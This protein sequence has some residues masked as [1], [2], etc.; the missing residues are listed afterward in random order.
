MDE[1]ATWYGSRPRPRPHCVRQRPSSPHRERGTAAPS[2]RPMSIVATVANLSTAE[3]LFIKYP[4]LKG[5]S[6]SLSTSQNTVVM[7]SQQLFIVNMIIYRTKNNKNVLWQVALHKN[8]HYTVSQKKGA[9]LTMAITLSVLDRFAKFFHC[10]K[11]Q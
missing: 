7:Q 11:E 9:T 6:L 1:D 4:A 10:C 2:F 5:I 3:L 8:S